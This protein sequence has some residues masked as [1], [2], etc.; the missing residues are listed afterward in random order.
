VFHVDSPITAKACA[1]RE[2]SEFVG[3]SESRMKQIVTQSSLVLQETL[4]R[5][6]L[7]LLIQ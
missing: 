3:P 1:D 4:L 6:P 5:Y 2:K 7:A